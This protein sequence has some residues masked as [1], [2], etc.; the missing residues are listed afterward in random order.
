LSPS[1]GQERQGT[2]TSDR[3]KLAQVER[4]IS[5]SKETDD[6]EL[7]MAAI[8]EA[9]LLVAQMRRWH[10]KGNHD[11][12]LDTLLS[13]AGDNLQKRR[14]GDPAE[15]PEEAVKAYEQA[16]TVRTREAY[17]QDRARI[18][19][20]LGIVYRNRMLGL[21]SEN[22][23]PAIKSYEA[24]LTVYTREAFPQEWVRVQNNLA[25]AYIDRIRGSTADN[26]DTA[27]QA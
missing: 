16:R 3:D 11:W 18:Q 24:A 19:F 21:K 17:P 20:H 1:R 15:N 12:V 6:P 5:R 23:E 7:A 22:L 26:V 10:S 4:L 8:R 25:S 14:L 27:I 13:S 9:L 2:A